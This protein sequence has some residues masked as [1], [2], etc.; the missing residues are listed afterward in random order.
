MAS[1][2]RGARIKGNNFE[3]KV[4]K[5]I[6]PWWSY[7]KDKIISFRRVPNSGGLNIKGDIMTE[8]LTD[9][10]DF[11]L[12]LELKCQERFNVNDYYKQA[13]HDAP[14]GKIPT[15]IFSKNNDDIYIMMTLNNFIDFTKKIKDENKQKEFTCQTI[16]KTQSEN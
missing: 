4:S 3:R 10:K 11:P 8:D 13:S 1:I 9:M 16:P 12:H 14:E 6:T 5:I 7:L 15:V 2:G